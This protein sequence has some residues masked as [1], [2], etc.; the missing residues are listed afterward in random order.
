MQ[1]EK[2]FERFTEKKGLIWKTMFPL[3]NFS[4]SVLLN[5]YQIV[6]NDSANTLRNK[7]ENF[8]SSKSSSQKSDCFKRQRTHRSKI[9]ITVTIKNKNKS[10]MIEISRTKKK[11]QNLNCQNPT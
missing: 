7:S 8:K 1:N 9:K 5:C 2:M 10:R 3:Y 6:E 11:S 4:N